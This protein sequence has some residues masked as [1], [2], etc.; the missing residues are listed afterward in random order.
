MQLS[1]RPSLLQLF[2]SRNKP[3]GLLG[4]DESLIEK[5]EFGEQK[6]YRHP[7]HSNHYRLIMCFE[8]H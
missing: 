4:M 5:E 3:D 1:R 8:V 2:G 7:R 6:L